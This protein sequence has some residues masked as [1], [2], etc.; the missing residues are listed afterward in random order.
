[1]AEKVRLKEVIEIDT[2]TEVLVA[3]GLVVL[4]VVLLLL[5]LQA[6][7]ARHKASATASTSPFLAPWIIETTSCHKRNGRT[8]ACGLAAGLE[9]ITA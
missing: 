9:T 7:A 3:D 5:L 2:E 8:Q 6:A 1:M 4:V